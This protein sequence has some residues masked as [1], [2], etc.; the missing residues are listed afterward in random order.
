MT[1]VGERALAVVGT[2]RLHLYRSQWFGSDA[3][4]ERVCNATGDSKF[5]VLSDGDWQYEK[6]VRPAHLSAQVD[7]LTTEAVYHISTTGI[8]VYHPVWLGF[9]SVKATESETE[10]V[11]EATDG[12]LIPVRTVTERLALRTGVQWV[13]GVLYRALSTGAIDRNGAR[14]VLMYALTTPS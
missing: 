13:K 7:F 1:S 3:T 5:D 8:Q 9:D 6:S 11:G 4:V 12:I 14:T 2:N 10:T